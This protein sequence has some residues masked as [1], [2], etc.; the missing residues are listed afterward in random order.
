MEISVTEQGQVLALQVG[1]QTWRF[2][3]IWLRDNAW[4]PATRDG[5][6]G[7]RLIALRDIP[8][9]THIAAAKLLSDAIISLHFMPEDRTIEYD[10]AWL[11]RHAYDKPSEA[12]Q[13]WLKPNIEV[14]D[15]ELMAHLPEGDFAELK[16]NPK[17][18]SAWLLQFAKYG[19]AKVTTGP[20][21]DG[22]LYQ[23]IDLFG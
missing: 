20:S 18:C 3:A 13:G 4:D 9:D 2:H 23:V 21:E 5:G 10:V 15:S 8:K 22:A 17:A 19:F 14:W 6:N 12:N 11:Q 16:Q 1:E 7:Q